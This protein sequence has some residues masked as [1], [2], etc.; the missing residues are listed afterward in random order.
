MPKDPSPFQG[1]DKLRIK[2][3]TKERLPFHHV[4][5]LRLDLRVRPAP[6]GH[7]QVLGPPVPIRGRGP[8]VGAARR[9][10]VRAR[11]DTHRARVDRHHTAVGH[12]RPVHVRPFV[13]VCPDIKNPK[14]KMAV[15]ALTTRLRS[16]V[17]G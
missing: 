6:R 10:Q 3:K 1:E 17:F 15:C 14:R 5:H 2:F 4:R 16:T 8:L 13:P 7:R 9:H 11:V 12:H